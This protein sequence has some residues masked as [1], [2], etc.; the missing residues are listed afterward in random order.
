[1]DEMITGL[2]NIFCKNPKLLNRE[3]V[4]DLGW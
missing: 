3:T 2:L 1:M 4:F